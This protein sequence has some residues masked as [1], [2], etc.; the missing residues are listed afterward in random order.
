MTLGHDFSERSE[1]EI[2]SKE[3]GAQNQRVTKAKQSSSI[4]LAVK[5][6]YLTP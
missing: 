5:Y 6:F 2:I 3:K 4:L 1:R